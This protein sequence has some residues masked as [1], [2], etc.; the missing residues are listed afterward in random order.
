M[1][2]NVSIN[3]QNFSK[4]LQLFYTNWEAHRSDVWGSTEIIVITTP[5]ISNEPRFGKSSAFN[6]W[7]MGLEFP[8]I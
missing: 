7:L 8:G 2:G 6:N 3:F 4:R 5:P 1:G